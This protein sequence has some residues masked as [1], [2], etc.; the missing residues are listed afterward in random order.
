[1]TTKHSGHGAGL[2]R[3]IAAQARAP[4]SRD[5]EAWWAGL[6]DSVKEA[7]RALY[8]QRTDDVR[9]ANSDEGWNAL[10]I[11]LDGLLADPANIVEGELWRLE[12]IELM[13]LRPTSLT[14]GY[15]D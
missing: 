9:Q 5:I 15:W 6:S 14:A 8:D 11:E 2:P 10:P 4:G 13:A 1:M 3:A 7:L 12:H